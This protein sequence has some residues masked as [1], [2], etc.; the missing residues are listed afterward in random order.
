M[1]SALASV[2]ASGAGA[3]AGMFGGGGGGSWSREAGAGLGLGLDAGV[4]DYWETG[5]LECGGGGGGG[6]GS[7]AGGVG[8]GGGLDETSLRMEMKTS[9]DMHRLMRSRQKV[10]GGMMV[11]C[12]G[13]C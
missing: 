8:G 9:M 10:Y 12:G 11:W 2:L 4:L 3:G 1:A 13:A 5:A 6:G 7:A